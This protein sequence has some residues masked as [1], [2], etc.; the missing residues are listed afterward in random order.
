MAKLKLSKGLPLGCKVAGLSAE[1]GPAGPGEDWGVTGV[2][3]LKLRTLGCK[4][5]GQL[6]EFK[7]GC[8]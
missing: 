2:A 8:L 4:F 3:K 6:P 7:I 5:A 1:L